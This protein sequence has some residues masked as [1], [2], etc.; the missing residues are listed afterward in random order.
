MPA[1]GHLAVDRHVAYIQSL[2]TVRIPKPGLAAQA[3]RGPTVH[4]RCSIIKIPR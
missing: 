4:G 1:N 3:Q 2:D